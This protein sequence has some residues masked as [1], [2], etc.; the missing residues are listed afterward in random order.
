MSTTQN[1]G[2]T[3]PEL[4]DQFLLS[5]WNGNSDIID[6]F[7][8]QV[9]AALAGKQPK[10]ILDASGTDADRKADIEAKLTSDGVCMLGSGD[11]YVTG[12]TMPAGTVLTGNGEKTRIILKSSVTDGA[13]VTL[14][15]NCILQNLTLDGGENT[16]VSSV[17]NRHGVLWSGTNVS[18]TSPINGRVI[19]CNIKNFS[20]A[21]LQCYETSQGTMNHIIAVAC[22][23]SNCNAGIHTHKSEFHKFTACRVT[24]CYYGALNNGG[25][26][27]FVGCDFTRSTVGFTMDVPTGT[28]NANP[29]HGSAVDC[30]FNHQGGD[31]H[32]TAIYIRKIGHGFSFVGCQFFFGNIDIADSSGIV[33][34]AC[35]F[36][37]YDASTDEGMHITVQQ[38]TSGFANSRIVFSD[39]NFQKIPVTQVAKNT[40]FSN[41]CMRG[42]AGSMI[43]SGKVDR[44]LME[45]ESD[46]FTGKYKHYNLTLPAGT[47]YL[48]FGSLTTD[49]THASTSSGGFVDS[50]GYYVSG[51]GSVTQ[52][53]RGSNSATKFVLTA[54][55]NR[56]RLI[57]SDTQTHSEGDTLTFSECMILTE[58]DYAASQ[59]FTPYCPS[60]H[61]MYELIKQLQ[62]EVAGNG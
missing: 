62:Q 33:F 15:S 50:N 53:T 13:A 23:I 8:G 24:D 42:G 6:A 19:S 44:N 2:L 41:C 21:G 1:L 54:E 20:G 30:L 7:A 22:F 39:C 5:D 11:Y 45:T 3:K 38:P 16:P 60:Q 48:C 32:G 17:G 57:P 14:K 52:I 59:Q 10:F 35:I 4:D 61:A 9:N 29:G 40:V 51:G 25:N 27:V 26:N 47:Y 49:D 56:L 18:T 31:N 43:D 37:R 28:T 36:G 58:A 34:D 55:C 12:I 46:T